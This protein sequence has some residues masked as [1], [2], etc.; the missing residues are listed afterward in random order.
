MATESAV[1]S[2]TSWRSTAGLQ[3]SDSSRRELTRP[4]RNVNVARTLPHQWSPSQ[5][6]ISAQ[7]VGVGAQQK[8]GLA[9]HM[10]THDTSSCR[11]PETH[12]S[13]K[14]PGRLHYHHIVITSQL[15]LL[16]ILQWSI[17]RLL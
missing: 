14:T 7:S 3:E 5:V 11:W 1:S 17:R 9:S 10:T 6:S 2:R 15:V 4:L 13:V 8:I 16:Y 12:L